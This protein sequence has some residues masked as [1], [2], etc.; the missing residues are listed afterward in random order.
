MSEA[1]P[2]RPAAGADLADIAALT[3]WAYRGTGDVASWTVESYLH[4]D[5]TTVQ[6]LCS[7]LPAKPA[8]SVLVWRDEAGVLLGHFWLEPVDR[9]VWYLGLL[10]VRP[11]RQD[12]KLGRRLLKAAED[13]ARRQGARRMQMTVV[14]V[15]DSLIE[16]YARRGYAPTGE[17]RPF[18]YGDDTF[19]RPQ[20]DD[21]SFV[22]LERTL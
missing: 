14:N 1:V 9:E 17:V 18:P 6:A 12:Q 5:R 10:S 13:L 11:D 22:V 15:R 3:N 4:G 16:W 8:A 20:R 2:L 7:D 21:L 19:G